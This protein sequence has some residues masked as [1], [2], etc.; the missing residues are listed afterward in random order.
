MKNLLSILE[1]ADEVQESLTIDDISKI[2]ELVEKL[3]EL[4]GSSSESSDGMVDELTGILKE[5]GLSFDV[6]K[7]KAAFDNSEETEVAL[8]ATDEDSPI[9]IS[10]TED[11]KEEIPGELFLCFDKKDDK[12][13]VKIHVYFDDDEPEEL[14]NLE[15]VVPDENES[16]KEKN[17]ENTEED[18]AKEKD[19]NGVPQA[20]PLKALLGTEEKED[21]DEEDDKEKECDC[22]KEDCPICKKK[23][24]NDKK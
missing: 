14:D 22:G 6:K 9:S 2:S 13:S 1:E 18:T 3:K 15:F 24:E 17:K 21:D 4:S 7:A 12:M 8:T 5:Y 11:G 20:K 23:K 19:E 16:G 10:Y